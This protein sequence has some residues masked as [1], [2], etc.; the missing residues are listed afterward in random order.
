M[1]V[2]KSQKIF[3]EPDEEIVF[4]VER[5]LEA[6]TDRLIL[7][8]PH[9]TIMAS[10]AVSLKILA[11]QVAKSDKLIIMVCDDFHA[12]QLA[13]K[14]NILV[15]AKISDIDKDAWI[16]AKG[17]K[18][19]IVIEKNRI[20]SELLKVR[21]EQ[22]LDT[23]DIPIISTDKV[24][25]VIEQDEEKDAAAKALDAVMK[26]KAR[27]K[28]KVV[29]T[30][31]IKI[32]AG[33]DIIEN[34]ELLK[35]ERARLEN[36]NNLSLNEINEVNLN[37]QNMNNNS[38]LVGIDMTDQLSTNEVYKPKVNKPTP[39]FI[40]DIKAFFS[41][42]TEKISPKKFVLIFV[43]II[44]VY[45]IVSFL[46]LTSVNISIKLQQ[47]D[48]TVKKTITA[49]PDL[50]TEYDVTTLTVKSDTITKQ[51]SASAEYEATGKTQTGEYAQGQILVLNPLASPVAIKQGQ[52]FLY[53]YLA[54][55]L[56]FIAVSADTIPAAGSQA[57]S[58]T[59]AVKAES[60]GEKYNIDETLKNFTL[61]GLS[62]SITAQN[63]SKMTGGTT[64]EAKAISK[65]DIDSA[66]L[67]LTD[68]L[69]ND[70]TTNIKTLLSGNEFILIGSEKF[71][72]DSFVSS[73]KAGE[74]GDKFTAELKLTI[75]AIKVNKATIVSLLQDV[76]KTDSGYAK[77][78]VKEPVID[79][80][81]I[82]SAN[83][84]S[85][86]AKANATAVSDLDLDALKQEIKGKSVSDTKELIKGKTGVSEVIIRYN[87][88][89]IPISMQ[90][91]P[92]DDGKITITKATN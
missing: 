11:S 21:Q 18:D 54:T 52:V 9:S 23:T 89:F 61:E 92:T 39:K 85:F 24:K 72:E 25:A 45:I 74:A 16:T 80:V 17:L 31:G 1:I 67:T 2:N 33:G 38:P 29:D 65:E 55:T 50:T 32:F 66:K 36:V 77:V 5:V 10:S 26:P 42:L 41:K 68:K 48:L 91:I 83:T 64:K 90:T 44:A 51:N 19:K 82:T 81:V 14:A 71:T 35:L 20:R 30:D 12:T 58:K 49:K 78:T 37:E 53:N 6:K 70:L 7:I 4:T 13:Q 56:R 73:A 84:A 22:N 57:G 62:T 8:V 87:P 28:G 60:F 15:K 40:Q 75:T 43:G 3:V 86:D 63:I 69:K 88:S 46:F 27:L 76:L 34:D 79:N 59:I 47:N